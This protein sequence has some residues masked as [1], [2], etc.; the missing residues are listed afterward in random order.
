MVFNTKPLDWE[1]S[2]LTTTPFHNCTITVWCYSLK[3]LIQINR[4]SEWKEGANNFL[5]PSNLC[6]H[7]GF[8]VL[9]ESIKRY[10]CNGKIWGYNH[11]TFLNLWHCRWQDGCSFEEYSSWFWS[12]IT[13]M[14]K[15]FF[16]IWMT[17]HSWNSRLFILVFLKSKCKISIIFLGNTCATCCN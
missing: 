9:L 17:F 2:A 5:S 1:S 10:W 15:S 8:F 11:L 12:S 14:S 7:G 4:R 6:I 3:K 13:F 16:S